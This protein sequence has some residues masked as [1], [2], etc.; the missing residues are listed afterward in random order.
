MASRWNQNPRSSSRASNYPPPPD[1]PIPFSS[2]TRNRQA[3][4][5]EHSS[6]LSAWSEPPP[7]D[8][9]CARYILSVMVLFLRQTALPENPLML[10]SRSSDIT[11]RDFEAFDSMPVM[12]PPDVH[13]GG[14][15]NGLETQEQVIRP[16]PSSA[17]VKSGK[18]SIS[19]TAHIP[20]TNT[21]YE[22][23]H[24]SMVKSSL[25][26][27]T[28][29]SKFAG[30]IIF[31]IS[32]SNWSVVFNRLRTKIHFLASNSGDNPDTI[33]LRLM[34]HSA[35]DRQRLVQVLNGAY[36][37]PYTRLEAQLRTCDM[38]RA[39]ILARQYGARSA[40]GDSHSTSLSCVELD[41]HFSLRVQRRHS[42]ERKDRGSARTRIRLTLFNS[43]PWQRE[44]PLAD[45][46]HPQLYHIRQAFR[47]F[48]AKRVCFH[49]PGPQV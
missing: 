21:T 41:R 48:S 43:F 17:S 7:L 3:A 35:L 25:S 18:F 12:A 9:S 49:C 15:S 47:R 23:T 38:C 11:F 44:N 4:A 30:R 33:D 28:L 22:K 10:P 13:S 2:A 32:A 14:Y 24:M 31:H 29:I 1:S 36:V 45:P 27:N 5:S 39:F 37:T 42:L 16:Q 6:T 19:S 34:A 46:S 8:D 20:A 26:V 40:A